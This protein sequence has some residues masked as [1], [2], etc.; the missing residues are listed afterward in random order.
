[1][2]LLIAG[3]MGSWKRQLHLLHRW[4]GIGIGLLVLLWF[5]SGIVMMYV[6]YPKLSEQE[7][8]GWLPALDAAQVKVSAWDAWQSTAQPGTP[9][10]VKINTVAG[11]PAYHFMSNG[12]WWSV[13]ADNGAALHVTEAMVQAA[14]LSATSSATALSV[15]QIDLDQWTFGSVK[16]HRPLYRVE[17]DD[18][19]GSVLYV[20]GRTGELVRDTTRSER[21]WNWAGSVIHW[22]YFTPLRTHGQPWRQVVMWTSGAAFLLVMA[23]MVLG[24]QRVR[25]RQPYASGRRSPYRGWQAWH[26]WLGLVIGTLTLTWLFSGW[27]S[28]TPF[29]WLSSPGVTAKDKL[30]FAGGP[31]NQED[32]SRVLAPAIRARPGLLELEWRRVGGK[33]YFSAL[34]RTG[35]RLLNPESG[36]VVTSIP[37][38]ALLLAVRATRPDIPLQ[39]VDLLASGD[40]YYYSHHADRPFPVMRVQFMLADDTSFYIDPAQG[41]LVGHVDSNGKWNRWLFNGLHQLDFAAS[42]RTR[43]VWDVMVASLSVLGAMLSTSGLVLGWRRLRKRRA[44]TSKR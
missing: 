20:S 33:L 18:A 2:A 8:M 36:T 38:E 39:A 5:G 23:G 26:H 4:L 14:A 11:R 3:A 22:I 29:D 27:L 37:N 44:K 34:E 25:L 17:A 19:A 12:R 40:S 1:M 30:A 9:G 43:P 13:W 6:P 21:A 32:L 7:R 16:M 28:V 15:D 35:R 24:I 42:L 10:A 31:L 41:T